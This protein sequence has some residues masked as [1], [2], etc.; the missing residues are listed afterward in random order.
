MVNRL[1][2]F[3]VIASQLFSPHQVQAQDPS[4]V[5]ALA[6]VSL[7]SLVL[8]LE[9]LTGERTVDVGNG[10]ESILSRHKLNTGNALAADWLQQRLQAL[11][12]SPIVQGF[13]AGTGENIL[14][15]KIGTLHPERKVIICGHY[16]AMPGGPVNA[17]AADDDGSGTCSVLEA[18]RVL[19][20]YSFEN[21]IVFALWDEEEQGKVGSAYY[22][23]ISAANDDTIAAVIN[24]DAISYDGNGDGLMRI[25]ARPV[26]N[27]LAIKDSALVV[28]TTYGL[29][30]NIAINNPGATYSDHASFWSE[31]YGAILVIEDFDNDGNPHYHTP[32]DLLQYM[33]LAYWQDLTRLSIGTT[34]VLAVPVN[35]PSAIADVAAPPVEALRVFP[36]PAA[37]QARLWL[38]LR[39]ADVVRITLCDALG[40]SAQVLHDGQVAAGGR[41]FP[42]PV[43]ALTPGTYLVRVESGGTVR[44]VRVIRTP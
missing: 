7:D 5:S 26:A 22:A 3:L 33:D 8:D 15:E 14:A 23:G 24:M 12:Y 32:T 38:E 18:A 35:G 9:R 6:A 39:Q 21:T 1:L 40:R 17:P 42:V 44:T 27:S 28:N 19:A 25:H 10:P 2:L 41:A 36:N 13:N 34:A 30:L 37:Q 4:I 11:G 31:G 16:D 20:P 43:H 29:N